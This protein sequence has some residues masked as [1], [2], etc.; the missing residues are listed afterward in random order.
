[1]PIEA[2]FV[3]EQS[4]L[5][6]AL[7]TDIRADNQASLGESVAKVSKGLGPLLLIWVGMKP[8]ELARVSAGSEARRRLPGASRLDF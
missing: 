1:M 8:R 5:S 4:L 6:P 7:E 3:N 2:A